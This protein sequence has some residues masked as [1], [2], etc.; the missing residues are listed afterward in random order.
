MELS[1]LIGINA[2]LLWWGIEQHFSWAQLKISMQMV[3][4]FST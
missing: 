2:A 4:F 3:I 1:P